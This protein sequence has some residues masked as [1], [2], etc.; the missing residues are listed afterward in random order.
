M[1]APDSVALGQFDGAGVA[2]FPLPIPN[3]PALDG[4]VVYAQ[5]FTLEQGAGW[6]VVTSNGLGVFIR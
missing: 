3:D 1:V 5:G 2:S 6:K 4:L